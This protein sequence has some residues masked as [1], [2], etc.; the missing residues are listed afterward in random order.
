MIRNSS[1]RTRLLSWRYLR[2]AIALPT[3]PL[4]W[5][6]CISHPLTQPVPEPEQ[7]MDLVFMIDNSPSMAPKV[8]KMNAQ[9]PKLLTALKDQT[10][11]T[12]PDLRV[13]IIDSD[14]GTGGMYSS[15][16]CGPNDTNGA[17]NFGDVGNFQMRGARGCGVTSDDALWLEY[18]KGQPINYDRTKDI[19]DVFA[20]LATNLGT[21]GCGEEHQLQAFEFALVAKSGDIPGRN[22]TQDTF[23]RPTAYLGLVFLSDE[24]DC[25]AATNDGMFGD[26]TDLRGESA[27]LRCATR[28]HQCNGVN[29]TQTPPGYPTTESFTA[30]FASCSARTDAC[31]NQT[32]GQGSTDT[33]Q[34]TDCS[35]LKDFR[36]IAQE[37]KDLKGAD[38]NEKLLVAGIFGWPRADTNM[39]S[40][41][42]K[43][44]KVPNP[45][46]ADTAHKDIFDYWPVCYDPDHAA[47][48]DGSFNQDAWGWG[49]EGG[50]RLSAFIDE[51]G[52][53]GYKYSICE[54]DFGA[55]MQGIG[56]AIA[57]KLQN[58]CVAAKLYDTDLDPNNNALG[59]NN[60]PTGLAAD[61]RVVY[62]DP[63]VQPNG[64]VTYVERTEA[65]PAC[66]PGAT[67]GHVDEDCWQLTIDT[68]K[69]DDPK[70][71]GQLV[72]I[73][74]TGGELDA[75]PVTEGTKV[76]M[77]CRTCPDDVSNLSHDSNTWKA[78]SYPPF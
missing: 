73:L 75:G 39:D 23:L 60:V 62:R 8:A 30:S 76:G 74:R 44:D 11:G 52:E 57:K 20:C 1:R 13:A 36:H 66:P 37:M 67:N 34:P 77:Q 58:L 49:A 46:S 45:N 12:Y 59:P 31:P 21:V 50:V 41:Q 53:N 26:K 9:F 65:L 70:S 17:S 71:L 19:A 63:H 51:F 4:A 7:Q 28:A 22:S 55:A 69:C 38:A 25:S 47:P 35:P 43:I 56:D 68:S 54:K 72:Q 29:L 5:W 3:L 61:C 16:S 33:S 14:L 78:C 42:Y 10:D 27:S 40:A 6:A 15:G 24:D 48:R 2:W 32:D 64:T 18:T